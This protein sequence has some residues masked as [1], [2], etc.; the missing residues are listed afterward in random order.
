[1]PVHALIAQR[2]QESVKSTRGGLAELQPAN[3][4]QHQ[5]VENPAVLVHGGLLDPSF[6]LQTGD[7]QVGE[8]VQPGL[9]GDELTR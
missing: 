6:S 8:V 2:Q 5:L 4:G 1:L 7:P 9:G 3:A